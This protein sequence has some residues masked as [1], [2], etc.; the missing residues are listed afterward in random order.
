MLTNF[1]STD[2]IVKSLFQLNYTM[3]YAYIVAVVSIYIHTKL[4]FKRSLGHQSTNFHETLD[5]DTLEVRVFIDTSW[6]HLAS[7]KISATVGY[8]NEENMLQGKQFHRE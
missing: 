8:L 7:S 4:L 6:T 5:H 1:S 3:Q 2:L